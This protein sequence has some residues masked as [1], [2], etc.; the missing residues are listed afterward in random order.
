MNAAVSTSFADKELIPSELFPIL[1]PRSDFH[2]FNYLGT[3]FLRFNTTRKPLDDPRVRRA[4]TMCIDK[5]RLVDGVAETGEVIEPLRATR[6]CKL[7]LA[8]RSRL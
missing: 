1:R 8:G 6:H 4:L 5:Q 7:S 3:Y 2:S